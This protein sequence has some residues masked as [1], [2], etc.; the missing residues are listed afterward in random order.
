MQHYS[1]NETILSELIQPYSSPTNV[2][3]S[4]LLQPYE[5]RNTN[6]FVSEL[7]QPYSL[8]ERV[9]DVEATLP[10]R[11]TIGGQE[12]P[13]GKGVS[14]LSISYDIDSY[15]ASFSL[16]ILDRIVWDSL[17][18]TTE[19]VITHGD[20]EHHSVI[21]SKTDNEK[22]GSLE[23][24]VESKSPAV[25]LAYPYASQISEDFVVEGNASEVVNDIAALEGWTIAWWMDS[26]PPQTSTTL[27]VAG[28]YPLDVIRSLVNELGGVLNS[29]PDGSLHAIKRQPVDSDKYD[30]AVVDE[31]ISTLSDLVSVT[32]NSD[33]RSGANYFSIS[34]SSSDSEYELTQEKITEST[35]LVKAYKVPWISSQVE[36]TTSELTSANIAVPIPTSPVTEII[37]ELDV[38]IVEGSGTV[39]KPCYGEVTW[40]YGTR[41]NL[42]EITIDEEGNVTTEIKGETLVNVTYLTKSWQWE[43]SCTD[44]ETAQ[45]NLFSMV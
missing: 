42:G 21:T 16:T 25:L 12:L 39:D 2:G 31:V 24:T 3:V 44:P 20:V 15:C 43:V 35:A 23:L 36:L 40:D 34:D 17:E 5:I 33:Q 45:F 32:S 38:S 18:N 13:I 10:S 37:E 41:T 14:Q 22:N 28:E 27:D 1:L 4:A 19:V 26:D 29:H 9:P 30:L 11:V 6:S 7:T 8:L